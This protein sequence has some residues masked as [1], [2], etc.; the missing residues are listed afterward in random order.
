MDAEPTKRLVL[1]VEDDPDIGRIISM[2]LERENFAVSLVDNAIAAFNR[3][4]GNWPDLIITDVMMPG[5]DGLE[6]VKFLKNDPRTCEIPI[7]VVSARTDESDVRAGEAA[8]AD[9]YFAK[10]FSTVQLME[11]VHK[12]LALNQAD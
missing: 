12:A 6:L 5:V 2:A 9:F 8:G 1:V 4:E 7:L 10:P 11:S 3:L